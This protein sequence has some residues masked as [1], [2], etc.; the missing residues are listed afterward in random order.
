MLKKCKDLK[1]AF[2]E[3]D[4]WVHGWVRIR[5]LVRKISD[6]CVVTR[7]SD[8]CIGRVANNVCT[9]CNLPAFATKADFYGYLTIV[10]WNVPATT[11]EVPF[12][13]KAGKGL[14]GYSPEIAARDSNAEQVCAR[15]SSRPC[16]RTSSSSA[17]AGIASATSPTSS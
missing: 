9:K 11:F 10:D 5:G 14:F 7:H 17:C 3:K 2:L 12:A 15:P 8:T 6:T 16:S 13:T 4:G 1:G